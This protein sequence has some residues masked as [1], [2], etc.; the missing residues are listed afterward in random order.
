MAKKGVHDRLPSGLLSSK[1]KRIEIFRAIPVNNQ[2][3]TLLSLPRA[4]Q[5]DILHKLKDKE[6]IALLRY[7]DPD[8]VTDLLQCAKSSRHKK[9]LHK[10]E[11]ELKDKVEYLLKF[12]RN[13]AA[14][15]MSVDYVE[16]ELYDTFADVSHVIKKHE[17]RTGRFPTALVVENGFL[18]GELPGHKIVLRPNREKIKRHVRRI[19]HVLFDEDEDAVI[20]TFQKHP[21]NKIVVLASDKSIMG[22]IYSDD[23]LKIMHQNPAESLSDFA[24]IS[25]E[26]DVLDSWYMKVKYRYK[27]LILNLFTAFMAAGVI[28]LFEETISKWVLLAIYM[29]IVAGMGGNAGTQAMAVAVRGIALKEVDLHSGRRTI[30]NEMIAGAVNGLIVGILVAVIATMFNSD[31][32]LGLVLGISLIVNLIIAGLFGSMIP[33]VL[34]RLGKDP[35]SSASIFITTATDVCGF[36]VFLGLASLVM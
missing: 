17:R 10:L 12:N 16:I 1:R 31:W 21:H 7:R 2:G 36:F 24:G 28:S 20:E 29:P 8:E 32:M 34:K 13:T 30:I 4:I 22:L 9:I 18:L 3:F 11:K 14:G 27:W 25:D 19:P 23:V 35:A 26:E 6:V 5:K 15:M 33:L